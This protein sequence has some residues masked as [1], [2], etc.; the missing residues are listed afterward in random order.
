MRHTSYWYEED[1]AEWPVS[2]NSHEEEPER[3]GESFDFIAEPNRF[4]MNVETDGSLTAKEVVLKVRP[5]P[6]STST[7][8]TKTI[9]GLAELNTRAAMM[10]HQLNN[11]GPAEDSSLPPPP[12]AQPTTNGHGGYAG[13]SNTSPGWGSAPGS[14]SGAANGWGSP[15]GG[16]QSAAQGGWG[17][18]MPTAGGWAV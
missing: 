7:V 3:E 5:H 16:A 18:P 8:L 2:N 6:L 12:V 15:Q 4:Y 17:S 14:G 10:I 11:P 13:T 9:Q 1:K